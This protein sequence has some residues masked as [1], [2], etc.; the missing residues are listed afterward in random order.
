MKDT[1]VRQRF[2]GSILG[3]GVR[4][5]LSLGTAV[6]LARCLGPNDYGRMAF[7]MASFVAIRG[8][9][10]MAS[11]SAFFTF[12]SQRPR[13]CRFIGHYWR[14][15]LC[16]FIFSLL[17]LGLLMPA[18]WIQAIW[19]G[20]SRGLVLLAF[21]ACFMQGSV[22]NIAT[23][24]AE[25]ERETLRVQKISTLLVFFHLAVI[26]FLWQ[27][28][29]L[30]LPF[31]FLALILEYGLSS[32]L[33]TRLY[34]G[35]VGSN[36]TAGG[37]SFKSV[38]HEFSNYCA[39]FIPYTLLGVVYD[40]GDRWMLQQWGGADQQA[41]Y[42]LATQFATVV[43]LATASMLR[44]FWK[45]IAEANYK[46]NMAR[47]HYL[48]QKVSRGLFILG[49]A[50]AGLLT[51]WSDQI[52]EWTLGAGYLSGSTTMMLMFFYPIHQSM[53]QIGGTMLYAVGQTRLYTNL[54][55][56]FMA[57]SLVVAYFLLAP[58]Q[59]MVPGLGMGS[60]GLACKMLG[61]QFIQVN[62][63][64][65]FI[66][67][68]YQW[69]FDWQTQFIVLTTVISAGWCAKG[70]ILLI[71]TDGAVPQVICSSVLTLLIIGLIIYAMPQLAGL[72]RGELSVQLKKYLY[73]S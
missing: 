61:M 60:R 63:I 32:W 4:G 8:L 69:K 26:F 59:A 24:M 44:I 43:L 9:L 41:Y 73:P 2:F 62:V 40:L 23:Q 65:W 46:G 27:A 49:A 22:W 57:V 53:G 70:F 64:A 56:I 20:E 37:E 68:K 66:A 54:G 21:A 15:I 42:A 13:T 12:L 1:S 3:N 47:V 28:G 48:Y 25:A 17:V 11:S 45:E 29:R 6:L 36:S 39:P 10:D 19:K 58:A 55:L 51:P 38:F 5:L 30:A 7:L 18:G 34:R 52:V 31:I 71:I 14:F 35:D 33:M 67:K 50:L 16:Q 72:T